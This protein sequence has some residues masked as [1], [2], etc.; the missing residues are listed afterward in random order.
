MWIVLAGLA[1]STFDLHCAARTVTGLLNSNKKQSPIP[2]Q[3]KTISYR[4]D[5]QRLRW[6][7]GEC[8]ATDPIVAVTSEEIVLQQNIAGNTSSITELD[9]ET[10]DLL[11]LITDI[12]TS[13]TVL[14]GG[15][16][17]VAPFSGMP[18]PKF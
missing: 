13:F 10:G 18:E 7:S 15:P 12:R 5:L 1:A 6:C 16:C 9:R 8:N 17:K 4:I 14:T 11:I 3:P 2:T